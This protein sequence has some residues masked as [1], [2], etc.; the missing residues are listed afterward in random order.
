MTPALIIHALAAVIWVGGMFFA[1]MI[2]RPAV[3]EWE[4]LERLKLWQ[5]VF[6]RFFP[7][8]WLCVLGLLATGYFMLFFGFGGFSGAGLH[9]HIMHLTGWIMVAL[10]LYLFHVPWLAFKRAVDRQDLAV[11]AARLGIIRKIVGT[12]LA[13]GLLTAAIGASGRYWG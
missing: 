11:A 3:Q 5:G 13:L 6:R 8:V 7:W 2:L 1:Y 9:V 10:F 12:N 4:A